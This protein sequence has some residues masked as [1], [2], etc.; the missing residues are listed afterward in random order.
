MVEG[1]WERR[2]LKG[3]KGLGE[4]RSFPGP[5]VLTAPGPADSAERRGKRQATSSSA[6]F[7]AL[8]PFWLASAQPTLTDS[9]QRE[10]VLWG[11]NLALSIFHDLGQPRH[12]FGQRALLWIDFSVASEP[13]LALKPG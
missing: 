4:K 3:G 10:G 7:P 1:A 11:R 5:A 13:G 2:I 8:P 9:L 6:G 12:E